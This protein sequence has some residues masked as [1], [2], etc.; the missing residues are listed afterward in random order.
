MRSWPVT[1]RLS[2]IPRVIESTLSELPAHPWATSRISMPRTPRRARWRRGVG[3]VTR[4][5]LLFSPLSGFALLV[6]LHE[7]GHFSAAKAVGM[8][9]E[10]FS[11][12]FPPTLVE[13]EGRGDRVRHRGH[14]RGRLREDQ[15]DEPGRGPPRGGP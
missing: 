15:R 13:Q 12:F 6:I 4:P 7:L 9:V 5:Q 14:P 2:G 10:K 8:R 11:L 3:G 1:C